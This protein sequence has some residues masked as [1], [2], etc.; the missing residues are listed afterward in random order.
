MKTTL[1]KECLPKNGWKV[2]RAIKGIII[3]YQGVLAGGTALSLQ[4]GHRLSVDLDFFTNKDFSTDSLISAIRKTGLNFRVLSE[5]E[6]FLIADIDGVK[7]S[8]FQ[9]DY[10]FV[11][12]I[13]YKDVL[14]A[15]I[16]D[17]AAMKMI[18]I[19]QRGT[20]R[21]F[22]DL[23]FILQTT[24]FYKIANHTVK[25]FGKERVNPIHIGKALVYF[26]DA[27]SNPDPVYIERKIKWE[28]IKKFFKQYAKQ[29]VLDMDIALKASK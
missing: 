18:A 20:K 1:H 11:T 7:F 12:P 9:Y 2:F 19:I 16:F 26:S 8:L 15:S 4:I 3:K 13:A 6:G 29:F 27:D 10:P 14:I 25:R 5:G 28:T 17:I 21:D 23:Y 24:P 22:A